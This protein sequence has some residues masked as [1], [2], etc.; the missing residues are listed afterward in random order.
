MRPL[1]CYVF[2]FC[3]KIVEKDRDEDNSEN[4]NCL[5][6]LKSGSSSA[7]A[8][9]MAEKPLAPLHQLCEIGKEGNASQI[10]L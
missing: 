3:Q 1:L 2:G 4:H 7:F 5:K 9:A 6:I 10:W 8:E